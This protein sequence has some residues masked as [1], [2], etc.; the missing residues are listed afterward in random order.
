[1]GDEGKRARGPYLGWPMLLLIA[2][3]GA[4]AGTVGTAL[5]PRIGFGWTAIVI[6]LAAVLTAVAVLWV[7]RLRGGRKREV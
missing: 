6:V 5:S 7:Q 3:G 2:A 4:V 1:M